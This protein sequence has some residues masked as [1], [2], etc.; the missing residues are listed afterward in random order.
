MPGSTKKHTLQH[1]CTVV[2]FSGGSLQGFHHLQS[3]VFKI[4]KSSISFALGKEAAEILFRFG[5]R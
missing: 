2:L 4:P 5:A 3:S 1:H